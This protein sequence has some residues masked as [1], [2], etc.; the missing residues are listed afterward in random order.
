MSSPIGHALAGLGIFVT[1][2]GF[3]PAAV[4]RKPAPRNFLWAAWLAFVALVPDLDY[5]IPVLYAL[6]ASLDDG[7]RITHSVVGCLVFPLLTALALSRLKLTP[8]TRRGYGIQ[9]C[10]AGLSHI[11]LDLL[12]GVWP[13]PLLWPFTAYR[14]KLPFGILPSAPSFRFDNFYMYRNHLIEFGV[15]IPLFAGIYLARFSKR[16]TLKRYACIA[17]LWLCSTGFMVWAFTLAR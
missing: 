8:A 16:P 12:V 11:V 5:L 13:L 14:F 7:L 9:V 15:I 10:L 6:R 1:G 2:A 3:P 17:A 4:P